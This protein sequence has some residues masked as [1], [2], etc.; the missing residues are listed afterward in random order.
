MFARTQFEYAKRTFLVCCER[1]VIFVSALLLVATSGYC[2]DYSKYPEP[3]NSRLNIALASADTDNIFIGKLP[4]EDYPALAKFKKLKRVNFHTQEGT[5]ADDQK[6]LAL[7]RIGLTNL[8]DVNLLNCPQVTDQGIK[9]LAQLPALRYLQLEGTSI[10]DV[11]C[12]ILG[13]KSS[14][15]G[16]NVANCKNVTLSGLTE[17]AHSQTLDE[18]SFSFDQLTQNEV[19]HLI[20]EF[21]HITWCEILDPKG[22]IDATAVTKVAETKRV[23]IVLQAIGALQTL[24]GEEWRPWTSKNLAT[25]KN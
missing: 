19:I 25:P 3:L 16:V 13:G 21:H 9:Y 4:I 7:S 8:F 24:R 23:K 22:E 12:K 20:G 10:A 15:T 17:L 1:F 6:L 11:G 2:D 5:G 18:F 14:V